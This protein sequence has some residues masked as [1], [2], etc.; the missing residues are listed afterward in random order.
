M[1]E[2]PVKAILC[3]G[4]CVCVCVAFLPHLDEWEAKD[5]RTGRSCRL[6]P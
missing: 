4:V 5:W 1:A 6:D 3:V 2:E